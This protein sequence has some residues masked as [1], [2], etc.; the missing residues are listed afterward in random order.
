MT[1][2]NRPR[3]TARRSSPT[4]EDEG[5]F[6][7]KPL[8]E[9]LSAYPSGVATLAETVES[10]GEAIAEILLN[11]G[12]SLD[13]AHAYAR[14][15]PLVLQEAGYVVVDCRYGIARPRNAAGG[16]DRVAACEVHLAMERR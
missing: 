11:A 2:K 10:G 16:V 9:A 4:I 12:A 7:R 13:D 5:P 15:L 14:R 8:E 6:A 1:K 3:T